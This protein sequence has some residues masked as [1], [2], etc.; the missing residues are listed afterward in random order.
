M[1]K[2]SG[3]HVWQNEQERKEYFAM[4]AIR[5]AEITSMSAIDTR[6]AYR[7]Y[8]MGRDVTELTNQ[9]IGIEPREDNHEAAV[10]FVWRKYDDSQA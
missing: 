8:Y 2:H 1:Y 9:Q 4:Q 6:T 7:L 10:H 5:D 3:G